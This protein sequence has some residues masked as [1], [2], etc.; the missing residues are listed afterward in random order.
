MKNLKVEDYELNFSP[1]IYLY[2]VKTNKSQLNIKVELNDISST[3]KITGNNDLKDG[4]IISII[5]TDSK[6]PDSPARDVT[7]SRSAPW[8]SANKPEWIR[9]TIMVEPANNAT[10]NDIYGHIYNTIRKGIPFPVKPEESFEIVRWTEKIKKQNPQ[11]C[12]AKI[13]E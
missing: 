5:V 9:K 8:F 6:L 12:K 3:Y 2:K 13:K 1:D 7:P 4:S 11:F 10:M